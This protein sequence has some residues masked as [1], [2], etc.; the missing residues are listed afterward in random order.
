MDVSDLPRPANTM[1]DHSLGGHPVDRLVLVGPC[2]AALG[3]NPYDCADCFAGAPGHGAWYGLGKGGV[4]A[5]VMRGIFP[6]ATF[7]AA[8]FLDQCVLSEIRQRRLGIAATQGYVEGI[9][10]RSCRPCRWSNRLDLRGCLAMAF[11]WLCVRGA[12][13]HQGRSGD[14]RALHFFSLLQNHN[15]TPVRSL[16]PSESSP[17]ARRKSRVSPKA[18]SYSM[19]T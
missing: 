9:D 8:R 14:H 11:L 4:S 16:N 3:G 19:P 17:S 12:G 18:C 10:D 15:R 5:K 1:K 7:H 2:C 6:P 13:Q